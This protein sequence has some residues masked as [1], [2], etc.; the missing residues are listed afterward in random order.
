MTT[1]NRHSTT[2]PGGDAM[3]LP[4]PT[5]SPAAEH[6]TALF[7]SLF[8]DVERMRVRLDEV[9]RAGP[10]DAAAALAAVRRDALALLDRGTTLGAGFVAAPDALADRSLYLAWWQGDDRQVLGESDAPAS[11]APFDYTRREWFRVPA[12][13]GHRHLTGP[14]V[15]YVCTDEYVVTCTVPVVTDGRTVGVVGADVL[16]ETLEDLLLP[17]LRASGATLVGVHGRTI[18]SADHRLAPGT[19]VD[20]GSVR[21]QDDCPGLPLK[22]V[23]PA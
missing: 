10:V 21:E 2:V 6:V 11:G 22:L 5:R 4:T 16:V 12:E 8:D 20:L 19:L 15:D 17:S 7:E 18:V 3:T 9:F 1:A 14:Y 23:I 13:T